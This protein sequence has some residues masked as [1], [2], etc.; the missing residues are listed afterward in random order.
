M[1]LFSRTRIDQTIDTATKPD[2][3][4]HVT[5]SAASYDDDIIANLQILGLRPGASWDQVTQA[6]DRLVS[7]LTPGPGASHRNVALAEQFLSEVNN[8]YASLRV[9][10]V[11]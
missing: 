7:D 8:A 3:S 1:F 6:H 4:D 9:L 5:D 2:Y 11:A 10:S